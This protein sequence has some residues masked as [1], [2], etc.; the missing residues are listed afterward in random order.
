M[1]GVMPSAPTKT[2]PSPGTGCQ[3]ALLH[4]RAVLQDP[5]LCSQVCGRRRPWSWASSVPPSPFAPCIYWNLVAPGKLFLHPC[6]CGSYQPLL[7]GTVPQGDPYTA[8]Q[9][10]MRLGVGEVLWLCWLPS[11]LA[12]RP[13]LVTSKGFFLPKLCKSHVG[14]DSH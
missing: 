6:V 11:E 8:D 12:E 7:E 14:S 13:G 1:L 4:T 9:H 10:L 2:P 3:S 5:P